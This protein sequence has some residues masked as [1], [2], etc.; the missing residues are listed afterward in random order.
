MGYELEYEGEVDHPAL[1][2]LTWTVW[3]YSVGAQNYLEFDLGGHE[4][5][6]NFDYGLEQSP[7]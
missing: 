2:T 4:I 7:D 1:G 6:K 5:V 3:E